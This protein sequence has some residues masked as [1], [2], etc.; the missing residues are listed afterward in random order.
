MSI[1]I[2][3]S[4]FLRELSLE[5]QQLLS[6]GQDSYY[7]KDKDDYKEDYDKED[8]YKGDKY[9]KKRRYRCCYYSWYPC[10]KY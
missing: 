10:K 5:E 9:G 2:I 4:D 8:D 7:G 1:Q 6:G 3:K